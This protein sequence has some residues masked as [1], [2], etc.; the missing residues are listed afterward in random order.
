M[1]NLTE[2]GKIYFFKTNIS[3]TPSEA[4][5]PLFEVNSNFDILKSLNI[6]G[7]KALGITSN[8]ELL[9]WEFDSKQKQSSGKKPNPHSSGNLPKVKNLRKKDFNFLLFKPSYHFH[10][11]KFLQITLNKSMCLGLDIYHNVLVWGQSKEGLLGLG[12]E[13]TSVDT[14]TLI[15]KLK[16]I[17]EVSLSEYHA[18]ALNN[19]GNAFSWGLGKYG[20]LGLE[21]S[22]YTPTPQAIFTE[23]FYSKVFCGNLITC[24]LDDNGKFYYFGVIIKQLGGYGNIVTLKSLLND[25]SFQDGKNIYFEKEIEEL[26]NESFKNIVIGNGFVA[27]LSKNGL[28]YVVEYNNKLTMLYSKYFLYNI[29]VA[30]NEIYGVARERPKIDKNKKDKYYLFK[31]NSKYSSENDLYSDIWS[32]TIWKFKE[33]FQ[34]ISNCELLETNNNKNVLLLKDQDEKYNLTNSIF[35]PHRKNLEI[36]AQNN[37]L[38]LLEK[39]V[40]NPNISAFGDMVINKKILPEKFLEFNNQYDDSYNI[41]YKKCKLKLNART[42]IDNSSIYLNN[43]KSR[44]FNQFLKN[45]QINNINGNNNKNNSSSSPF[46]EQNLSHNNN[47]FSESYNVQFDLG[48]ENDNVNIFKPEDEDDILN[49]KEK[50]LNKYRNEVDNIISNFRSKKDSNNL[51]YNSINDNKKNQFMNSSR[52]SNKKNKTNEKSL[53]NINQNNSN[54][55]ER[56]S[57]GGNNFYG[58]ND[59]EGNNIE[60]IKLKL[61]KEEMINLMKLDNKRKENIS[62]YNDSLSRVRNNII[63]VKEKIKFKDKTLNKINNLFTLSEE[64]EE[65]FAYGNNNQNTEEDQNDAGKIGNK[66]SNNNNNIRIVKKKQKLKKFM[67]SP[68]FSNL[69]SYKI[70]NKRK[71]NNINN[72]EDEFDKTGSEDFVNIEE[73]ETKFKRKRF[74]SRDNI[75]FKEKKNNNYDK[76]ND[77][78]DNLGLKYI[79]ENNSLS[80]NLNVNQSKKKIIKIKN[81]NNNLIEEDAIKSESKLRGKNKSKQNNNNEDNNNNNEKEEEEEEEEEDGGNNYI[82][83]EKKNR[84]INSG[85]LKEENIQIINKKKNLKNRKKNNN[86]DNNSQNKNIINEENQS[87]NNKEN[88]YESGKDEGNKFKTISKQKK[89]S[90]KKINN[91]RKEFENQRKEK[92]EFEGEGDEDEEEGIEFFDEINKN[93]KKI[94]KI[95]N[96]RGNKKIRIKKSNSLSNDDFI[97]IYK[98]KEMKIFENFYKDINI[99]SKNNKKS[100]SL[101]KIDKR[102]SISNALGFRNRLYREKKEKKVKRNIKNKNIDEDENYGDEEEEEEEGEVINNDAQKIASNNKNKKSKNKKKHLNLYQKNNDEKNLS[103]YSD[104]KKEYDENN[105][106]NYNKRMNKNINKKIDNKKPINEGKRNIF[107]NKNHQSENSK[108]SSNEDI[109]E[110]IINESGNKKNQK[111]EQ[112]KNIM[113]KGEKKISKNNYNNIKYLQMHSHGIKI[114]KFSLMYFCDLIDHYMKKKSFA[115]CARQIA[116]YQKYLEIKFSLKILFRVMLKRIIFYKLKFMHRYKRINKYLIKNKIKNIRYAYKNKK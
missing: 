84:E 106:I 109:Y 87:F 74:Y 79:S 3:E 48:K 33:E 85:D 113:K 30:Y 18:V 104:E 90:N 102:K 53:K 38:Q 91:K 35:N 51:T 20:E 86:I 89:L 10:K 63:S 65:E 32:T 77:N 37:E 54:Q 50:E 72:E 15:P 24:F 13:I 105:E 21:R 52:D 62:N 45:T 67:R 31:W 115:L 103:N 70:N 80:G 59:D 39:S 5:G 11:I 2:S 100:N 40:N 96:I 6:C 25:Q 29:T 98:P 27:L 42:G 57:S 71:K 1:E 83:K 44:T 110:N 94:R 7:A 36:S 93:G 112:N 82:K 97:K 23:T 107:K 58:L 78:L 19:N 69:K 76:G 60:R 12:Y 47:L 108:N 14:P 9:E 28:L 8:N 4:F 17:K 49:A 43:N 101:D 92:E 116:N 81:G 73:L 41:K 66:I 61:S 55:N 56:Y 114:N 16:E 34:L 95:K 26:E 99:K 88:S 22:I 46:I 75:L 64:E 68:S 111:N